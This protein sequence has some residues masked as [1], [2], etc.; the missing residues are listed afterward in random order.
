MMHRTTLEHQFKA[1]LVAL[2]LVC[3]AVWFAFTRELPFQGHYEVTAYFNTAN[4][5]KQGQPV[6]VAGVEVGEV[7]KVEHPEPGKRLAAITMRIEDGGRPLHR[8]A[9]VKIRPRLFLEGNWFIDLEPGTPGTAELPDGGEIPVQQTAGPVQLGE[10]F[11]TL[12]SDVRDNLRTLVQEYSSALEGPG[13]DGYRRSIRWWEPAYRNSA[14]VQDATLGEQPRD[15]SEY[16][17]GAGRVAR[18][19]DADPEALKSLIADFDTAAGAFARESD[20]LEAAIDEL[21]RTLTAARPA[22]RAL[23]GALPPLR[24]FAADLRPAVVESGRTIEVSFPFIRQLR[25]LVSE[26]EARGL[27]EDLTPTVPALA[28]LTRDSQPLYEE[29]RL[30]SGCENEVLHPWAN[31]KVPDPNFPPSGRVFEEAPKPLPGLAGESRGGDANGQWVRVLTSGGDRT[32]NIGNN[33]FAQAYR[34]ILGT[35]PP[36]PVGSPPMR[37]DVPCET[38]EPPDLRTQAGPGDPEVARGLPK[39]AEAQKRYARAKARAVKWA[40]GQLKLEGLTELRVT[41]R[42]ITR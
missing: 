10:L 28:R 38:Q 19:L 7:S 5:V 41:S 15:L 27:I 37:E 8:D 39:T 9:T 42:E 30:A 36:K 16:I 23:D 20:N 21:P 3:I 22:L 14:I 13:A 32:I 1:G 35:N 12:R 4:N 11:A 29:L 33:Q 25:Q 31:D 40:R 2:V 34:P 24:R 26:A 18:G 6:R 17:D